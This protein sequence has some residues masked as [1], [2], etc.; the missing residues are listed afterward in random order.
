MHNG[1]HNPDVKN[2]IDWFSNVIQYGG[3]TGDVF[4][5]W[6]SDVHLEL[7]IP[8]PID[9]M[10]WRMEELVE[11]PDKNL[12]DDPEVKDRAILD[13]FNRFMDRWEDILKAIK[14]AKA[15]I[16]PNEVGDG[17]LDFTAVKALERTHITI[18]R[19]ETIEALEKGI[20]TDI[21]GDLSVW[22]DG[23]GPIKA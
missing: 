5:I 12:L 4:F 9:I 16:L 13:L 15:S 10:Y 17:V 19:F 18:K 8:N 11:A 7:V 3:E 23:Q 1:I 14:S 22:K 20:D 21:K 6:V 2:T